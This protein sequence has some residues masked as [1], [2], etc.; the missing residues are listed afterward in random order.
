MTIQ[1]PT[2]HDA[3]NIR[4]KRV[5]LRLDLNL[6]IARGKV[7]DTFRLDR[8]AETLSF[9]QKN[10]A[11]TLVVS[12]LENKDSTEPEPLLPVYEVF[13]ERVKS[14]FAKTFEDAKEALSEI[15]EGSF[16]FLEN[17]RTWPGEKKNDPD[18]AKQL[19]S[20]V[21]IYVNDA[22]AVS[23]RAHASIVGVPRYLPCFAG[24]L[25]A[26][27]VTE[28]SKAFNPAEPSLVILG[29]AKFETKMPLV[30]RFLGGA[31]TVAVCGALANDIYRSRGYETGTSLVSDPPL[32]LTT[33]TE[34]RKL[35]V[36]VDVLVH[37]GKE[38]KNAGADS[39][40]PDEKIVDAG[41]NSLEDLRAHIEKASF[42]LWN[43]PLGEYEMGFAEGT[44][45]IAQAI[46]ESD[47]ESIVGGGDSLT[48]I[49]KLGLLERFSFVSTGGGAML[50]FLANETLPG[51]L[52]LQK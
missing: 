25:F 48:L 28:L 16:V 31:D 35:Y 34:N 15:A 41:P 27:E 52:A 3:G 22:F 26:E 38:T 11:R 32:D 39:V 14:V 4:G 20:L 36:P 5:L 33:V 6:S 18:F 7:T 45:A 46:A 13:Q 12:H 43:G 42:I 40:L 30:Q 37:S 23:H 17:I 29:G 10:G 1:L 8:V 47:A 51:I 21:D 50:E 44:T 49:S 24:F 19:A 2:L 9:L